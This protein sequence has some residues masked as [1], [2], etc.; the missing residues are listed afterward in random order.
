MALKMISGLEASGYT[1][2]YYKRDNIPGLNYLQQISEAIDAAKI[3]LLIISPN[4]LRSHHVDTEVINAFK[5]NKSFLPILSNITT[6]EFNKTDWDFALRASHAISLKPPNIEEVMPRVLLGINRLLETDIDRRASIKP[7]RAKDQSLAG[8]KGESGQPFIFPRKGV[9]NLRISFWIVLW[10][11]WIIAD[12]VA[13]TKSYLFG[14][15]CSL[16]PLW[17]VTIGY[18]LERFISVPPHIN[19][20]LSVVANSIFSA[21]LG[22]QIGRESGLV[23]GILFGGAAGLIVSLGLEREDMQISLL[24]SVLFTLAFLLS[25]GIYVYIIWNSDHGFLFDLDDAGRALKGSIFA[26]IEGGLLI[27]FIELWLKKQKR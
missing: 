1:V 18:V 2:W 26:L 11:L 5:R 20:F 25:M 7:N 21:W 19:P 12:F 6:E 16:S 23:F 8:L 17:I 3:F 15:Y 24:F 14:L 13:F 27:L 9:R 10:M 4:S 22:Y